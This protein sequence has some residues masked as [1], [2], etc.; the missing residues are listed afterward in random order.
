MGEIGLDTVSISDMAFSNVGAW[1]RARWA[2]SSVGEQELGMR[3]V[4]GLMAAM[5]AAGPA[6]ANCDAIGD[7]DER[8]FC[9]AREQASGGRWEKS[10]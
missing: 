1:D 10:A 9:A 8:Y 6:W 4:V 2:L 7:P 3:G 5:L